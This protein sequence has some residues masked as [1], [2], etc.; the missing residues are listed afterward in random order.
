MCIRSWIAALCLALAASPAGAQQARKFGVMSLI[1][2]SFLI[3]NHEG[4]KGDAQGSDLRTVLHLPEHAFDNAVAADVRD[5]IREAAPGSSVVPLVGAAALYP[6]E[7][8]SLE[9][10]R[11]LLARVQPT[12]AS[13]GITHLVMLTK[14]RRRADVPRGAKEGDAMLEGVGFYIDPAAPTGN[15]DAPVTGFLGG[16]SYFRL[17]LVDAGRQRVVG[18]RDVAEISPVVRAGTSA[19]QLWE[20]L[21]SS[22]KVQMV[23]ALVR[24]GARGAVRE[25]LRNLA[26]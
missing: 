2:D 25:L 3:V 20:S 15:R 4:A 10:P 19:T 23:H 26:D 5:A 11:A 16:F 7:G 13:A 18:W 8:E 12:V 17:W 6:R 9:D 21:P 24:E 1:G 14:L 22:E